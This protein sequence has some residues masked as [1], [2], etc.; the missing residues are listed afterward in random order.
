MLL[1]ITGAFLFLQA[2]YMD[3]SSLYALYRRHPVISTDSRHISPGCIFVA[4]K[5]EQHDGHAFASRALE[6]GAALAVVADPSLRGEKYF[7]VDD[8]L[9]ALQ[10]LGRWHRKQ[11]TIPVLAITGSNGKTTTKELITAVLARKYKVHAT[12]GNLNNHIGVPLTLLAMPPDTEFLICEMGANHVGEI[13]FLCTLAE[14]THGLITNIGRAHL[15]GFGSFEGVKKA[16]G[17][18]FDFLRSSGGHSFVN[19]DDPS[20]AAISGSLKQQTTY[21]LKEESPAQVH[22][23]FSAQADQYGFS[24]QD[25]HSELVIHSG[26]FGA[27]NASNVL[28]AYTVGKHFGVD[29][30]NMLHALS[31]FTSGANRSEVIHQY[32][33]TIIKDAYNANPSSM[34]LA[35]NAFAQQF[36][37]G[38][39]VLGDMKELGDESLDAHKN[40]IHLTRALNIRR[41]YLVGSGFRSA[42]EDLG[43]QDDRF[44]PA[45]TI[46]VLKSIWDWKEIPGKTVLLKG[47]RSMRLERLLED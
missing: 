19:L 21:G 3:L 44:H 25:R 6:A 35:L 8:T 32:G 24:L 26:L 5:G 12:R 36:S 22:F 41:V 17:E 30:H 38:C 20:L 18:L 7:L 28:A 1:H 11:F 46:E 42:L 15:E 40:I 43:L 13:A 14:P 10:E 39:V 33:C 4:L 37:E 47:S 9:T 2:V 45:E 27:Y 16:K 29:D 31:S 23:R 34:E